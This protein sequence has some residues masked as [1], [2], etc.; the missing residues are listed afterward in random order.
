MTQTS[1]A[2]AALPGVLAHA[3]AALD[4][5]R[6]RLFEL[7]RI[8]SISAQPA[9]AGDCRSAAEWVAGQLAAMGFAAEVADTAGHPVVFAAHPGPAGYT[10]PHILF[11]GHYDVQPP[12]P[13]D[14]WHSPPFEPQLVDGPR[15]KRFVARGA[16]DDKGQTM[17]FLEALRAW[18]AAGGGIPA[19]ITVLIEGEE[20]VGSLN[21]AP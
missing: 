9:H 20:E 14:L 1:T 18:H 16:V 15:G 3:D 10:G 5:S 19:R 17:M 6:A 21:L 11:Y 4:A 12:D 8:P 7:L 13:L 2:E